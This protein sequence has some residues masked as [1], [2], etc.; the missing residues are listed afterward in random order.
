M[1]HP[2]HVIH[3][4][5]SSSMSAVRSTFLSLAEHTILSGSSTSLI[6]PSNVQCISTCSCLA[7]GHAVNTVL[8]A[9]ALTSGVMSISK[10][11]GYSPLV[12]IHIHFPQSHGH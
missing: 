12:S 5:Q 2:P 11:S 4:H 7:S 1:L 10:Y 9:T 8:F 6:C 3:H